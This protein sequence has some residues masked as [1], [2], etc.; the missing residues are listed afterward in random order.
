MRSLRL[1]SPLL[2]LLAPACASKAQ[3]QAAAPAMP[4]SAELAEQ[5]IIFNDAKAAAT[6][7][8]FAALNRMET[9]FRATRSRTSS[10]NWKLAV[11]YAWIPSVVPY[12]KP[13]EKCE[14]VAGPFL[15]AWAA[16]DRK[17]PA[18]Y[19][20]KANLLVRYAWC[21]RGS[22]MGNEVA[23][24]AWAP[25]RANVE[26]AYQLLVS[27]KD[28]A[29]IDPEY[30]A[31]MED[32]YKAQGRDK[33]EFKA[34]LT[35]AAAREPYY[36]NIYF[37]AY[38]YYQPQWFGS[39]EEIDALARFAADQTEEQDGKGAYARLYWYLTECDCRLDETAVDRSL[40]KTAMQDV[41]DRYPAD[42]NTAHFAKMSCELGEIGKAAH[43][44][45]K[46]KQNDGEAWSDKTE[47]EACKRATSGYQSAVNA[48]QIPRQE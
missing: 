35:E 37:S 1:F 18:P 45:G 30:Y 22:G 11:F 20:A 46:L 10:G 32:I 41:V 2:L 47:W 28:I 33:D 29:S 12:Q 42:W 15:D 6:A 23:E 44:L 26:A 9:E 4:Y 39:N 21:F 3:P 36:Y 25:F 31:V 27:H 17:Q 8:D 38:H 5:T 48:G 16:A 14:F 19:I 7:K 13:G 43:F 34:L 40:L 24:T